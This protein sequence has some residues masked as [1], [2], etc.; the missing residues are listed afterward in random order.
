[1][2]FQN[3]L[4]V[5]H[6]CHQCTLTLSSFSKYKVLSMSYSTGPLLIKQANHMASCLS[7]SHAIQAELRRVV[8]TN[9]VL[10]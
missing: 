8:P 7:F 6:V 1:M 9:E 2:A 5:I 10:L 4:V 3:F